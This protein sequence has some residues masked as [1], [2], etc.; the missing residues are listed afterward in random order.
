MGSLISR[1]EAVKQIYFFFYNLKAKDESRFS[2]LFQSFFVQGS[3]FKAFYTKKFVWPIQGK[4][5]SSQSWF[6]IHP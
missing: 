5:T 6:A 2:C 4:T 1:M 3:V